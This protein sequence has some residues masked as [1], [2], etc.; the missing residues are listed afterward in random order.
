L[1]FAPESSAA[2]TARQENRRCHPNIK[3]EELHGMLVRVIA[4]MVAGTGFFG[5]STRAEII[6]EALKEE[7]ADKAGYAVAMKRGVYP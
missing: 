7:A 3:T 2:N 4:H 6:A 1:R 5:E